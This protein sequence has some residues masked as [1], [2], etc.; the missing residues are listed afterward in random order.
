MPHRERALFSGISCEWDANDPTSLSYVPTTIL[1][2]RD[3]TGRP[4]AMLITQTAE[5]T[6]QLGASLDVEPDQLVAARAA[7]AERLTPSVDP[8]AIRMRP[9]LL[10][11][12]E[13][14]IEVT[15]GTPPGWVTVGR[16]QTSGLPPYAVVL[17]SV[18]PSRYVGELTGA[19]GGQHGHARITFTSNDAGPMAT[20]DIASWFTSGSVADH[21]VVVPSRSTANRTDAGHRLSEAVQGAQ[22]RTISINRDAIDDPGSRVPLIAYVEVGNGL[23]RLTGPDYRL[24]VP[25]EVPDGVPITV[26]FS[27][28]SQ[29]FQSAL[30]ATGSGDVVIEPGRLGVAVIAVDANAAFSSGARSV[31]V[32][33]IYTSHGTGSR[34]E[35]TAVLEPDQIGRA[36]V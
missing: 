15:D 3:S 4:A 32:H 11:S 26:Y 8:T 31:R 16:A 20:V 9:A 10:R 22:R 13:A 18:V 2:E 25:G 35:R 34:S 12:V 27:D 24:T 29:P 6:V 33:A 1:P 5:C 19:F 14:T 36:H 21:L 23:G 28:G 17:R 7:A 30:A